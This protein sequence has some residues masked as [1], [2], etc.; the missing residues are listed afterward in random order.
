LREHNPEVKIVAGEP[1]PGEQVQ[2]LRN[3]DEGFIP[4][5]L[6]LELLDRK[7][8]VGAEDA[9]FMTRELTRVE[10]IFAGI[11]SGAALHVAL[12]AAKDL[13][14]GNVV[15]LLADGGW[16]YLSSELWTRPLD[17]VTE[18]ISRGVWM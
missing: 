17:Q 10:G 13:E 18:E 16:K 12:R 11:S 7:I 5:I 14:R 9:L 6:D 4:P 8:V 2:G 15:V 1:H 3:L